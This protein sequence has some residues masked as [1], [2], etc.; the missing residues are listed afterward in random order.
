MR[1]ETTTNFGTDPGSIFCLPALRGRNAFLIHRNKHS[2]GC[3]VQGRTGELTVDRANTEP[4]NYLTRFK[5]GRL[6]DG[7]SG[8]TIGD[9]SSVESTRSAPGAVNVR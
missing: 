2:R 9:S 8:G 5:D 4:T 6:P 3:S 1:G 7:G